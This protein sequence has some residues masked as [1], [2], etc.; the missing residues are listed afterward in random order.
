MDE[1]EATEEPGQP[2][3]LGVHEGGRSHARGPVLALF[4]LLAQLA[5][6][7]AQARGALRY[8][9]ESLRPEDR[10]LPLVSFFSGRLVVS[11]SKSEVVTKRRPGDVGLYDRI[12][13]TDSSDTFEELERFRALG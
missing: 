3:A 8:F 13:M 11:S 4:L 12:A 5:D 2:L 1:H 7:V 6:L 10:F 9:L